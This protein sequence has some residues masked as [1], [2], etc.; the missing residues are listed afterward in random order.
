MSFYPP[1][2]QEIVDT[3]SMFKDQNDRIN[4]LIDYSEKY[5]EV[6][7]DVAVRPYPK[8]QKVDYCESEAYVWVKKNNDGT[9]KL[10][11]AVENPQGISAKALAVILDEG[12][13]GET[14]ENILKVNTDIV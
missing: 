6:P 14:A 3:I 7:S 9:Y 12:L 1:K 4:V 8:K 5:K 11:F 2:L 10:Y 13:S